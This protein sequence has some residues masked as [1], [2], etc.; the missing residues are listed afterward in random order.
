MEIDTYQEFVASKLAIRPP[1]GLADVPPLR[2]SLFPFQ[3]ALVTWALRRGRCALFTSTGTGKTRMELAYADAVH[4]ATGM[5]VLLLTPL[6]VA[7]QTA[8]EAQA[9]GIDATIARD[10]RDAQPGITITNYDRVHL[11]DADRFGAIVLDE[12]SILK[13]IDGKSRAY[14]TKAFAHAAFRLCATATPAPNDVTELG[15]HAEFLGVC[16]RA[17]MLAEYFV[18]DASGTGEW[19]LKGHARESYWRWLATWAAVMRSP[20]DIGFDATGYDLPPL[21]IHRHIIASDI[22]SARE[23]GFL[24]SLPEMGL[25]AVR[26][27]KRDSL[28]QRVA[29][30]AEIVAAEPD[31]PWLLFGELNVET[32]ALEAAIPGAIQV[33]GADDVDVKVERLLSFAEGRI[34]VLVSKASIAGAG[35]NFQ[36]CARVLFVGAT[37][38]WE[39]YHQAIRRCWRFRQTRPVH[40]HMICGDRETAAIEAIERKEAQATR[41]IDEVIA[42][43]GEVI[44]TQIN[45]TSV[46]R[47]DYSP[48]VPMRLPGWL[49]TEGT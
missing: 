6:A 5:D 29:K 34:R 36:H 9:I 25:T 18:N 45:G 42:I 48:T 33:A 7:A 13:G 35:L 39:Q 4:R 23:N 3:A 1:T 44:K 40:V 2:G 41:M 16:T 22:A 20:A 14:L 30:A 21:H 37:W 8:R 32:D 43:A 47:V 46:V 11:L 49:R 12:S 15:Q 27:A 38:S 17:E 28:D 19:R 24:F 10:A 26:A 31:E